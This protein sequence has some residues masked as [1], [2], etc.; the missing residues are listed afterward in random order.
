M[1]AASLLASLDRIGQV[2]QHLSGPIAVLLALVAVSAV[3]P[4]AWVITH[5][6]TVIAHEAA[7][8]TFGSAIGGTIGGIRLTR[9]AE[10]VTA[11][12]G[13]KAVG[14]FFTLLVGYLGPSVFGIGAAGLIKTGHIISVLWVALLALLSFMFVLRRSFGIVTVVVLFVLLFLVA[15]FATV[16]LQV[17]T[18]YGISWFLL[19][20]GMRRILEIFGTAAGDAAELR[21]MTKI[22]HRFWHVFWMAGTA[23]GLLFGTVLLL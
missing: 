9:K 12:G 14:S 4:G 10:G 2:Q 3:L 6:I 20:S 18:S 11:I 1:T 19:V 23:A 13:T 22:P 17:V 21:R 5:H 15:A 16:G 7:H 8:A